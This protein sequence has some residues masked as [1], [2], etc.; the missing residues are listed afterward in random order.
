[1]GGKGLLHRLLFLPFRYE[2]AHQVLGLKIRLQTSDRNRLQFPFRQVI[3]IVQ[4]MNSLD[5][6]EALVLLQAEV[7]KFAT[8]GVQF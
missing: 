4:Q 5:F 7:G 2:E 8:P 3:G 1:M 6:K